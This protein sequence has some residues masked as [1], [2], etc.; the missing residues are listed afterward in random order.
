MSF[1]YFCKKEDFMTD[2]FEQSQ[3][4]KALQINLNP[5]FYGTIAEIGGGQEVARSFFQAGG[6][7]GT[8]AKSISAYD[9]TF[10]DN[11][12][13]GGR[14]ER[15]VSE[16]R[17]HQMLNKEFDQLIDTL[18]EDYGNGKK[19]FVFAD[20]VETLNYSKTNSGH[21]WMGVKFQL[22][23]KGQP[24]TVIIHVNLLENDGI[25]QQ[26]TLG[27]LGVNLIYACFHYCNSPNM[28]LQSLMDN[29][30]KQRVDINMV[31][32]SGPDLDYV[33]NRLL[34]VQLVKNNMTN[35]TVFDRKGNVCR[36]GDF[37]YKKNLLILRGSFR[38]ITFVG[39]DML[40]ASYGFFKKNDS[41]F[42]TENTLQVCEITLNNLLEEG[43]FDER[44]FLE[45][46]DLLNGMGQNVMITN[47]EEFYKLS[48]Y[49]ADMK[50]EKV[51]LVMGANILQKL[52][53]PQWYKN[54]RGGCLHAMGL[55]FSNDIQIYV[56]PYFDPETTKVY[57]ADN[58]P[59]EDKMKPLY[60]YLQINGSVVDLPNF[61][62]KISHFSSKEVL[63]RIQKGDASWEEMVPRYIS[64]NIKEKQLFGCVNDLKSKN[65]TLD[66]S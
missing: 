55:L 62:K 53:Q 11:L 57:T 29:L 66:C 63:C 32:M 38:P 23:E 47:F 8:I 42:T 51:R 30:D 18:S 34:S 16:K 24:N 33:D 9:K 43:D 21:G 59:V 4:R 50:A 35:A 52:I 6:A 10:S 20:T 2:G 12:Y 64:K 41:G 46:V 61:N 40:K 15:Y 45:R 65:N 27:T 28:F 22:E 48:D 44:D 14:K 60:K 7:S 19:F 3:K 56:Y 1:L 37:L 54:L 25:L 13:N 26:Y 31:K 5:G 36:P 49:I 39:F 17:L 58:I